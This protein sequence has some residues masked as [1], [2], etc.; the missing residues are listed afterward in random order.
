MTHQR[1]RSNYFVD[2][3]SFI[4]PPYFIIFHHILTSL[5]AEVWE[6]FMD[7]QEAVDLVAPFGKAKAQE[8]AEA[9]IGSAPV[10]RN[11]LAKYICVPP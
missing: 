11:V 1:A 7:V 4:P 6:F 5:G 8:A 10:A 9:R 3:I 2:Y